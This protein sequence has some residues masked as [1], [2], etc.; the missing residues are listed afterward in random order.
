MANASDGIIKATGASRRSRL[1]FQ[2]MLGNVIS[3]QARHAL[4]GPGGPFELA[5]EPV[6]GCPHTVF[7]R[8]PKTLRETLNTRSADYLDLV[9]LCSPDRTWTF[10][11]ALSHIDALAVLLAERYQ[12]K[13]GDRVAIVAANSAEYALLMWAT[14]TL[15]AIVT[16]LNGWWTEPELLAGVALTR[17]VLIAGDERR[18]AR[19]DRGSVPARVP[20]RLIDGLLAEAEAYRGQAPDAPVITEDSPAVI[21]FT[22]GTTG[23]PKGATLSHRNLINFGMVQMLSG[24]LSAAAVPGAGDAAPAAPPPQTTTIVTSPMF[25]I[26]GL[27]GVF[28]TG[29]FAHAKLV[30]A[31][32]G[33]WDP[34][35]YLALTTEHAVTAWSGVPTH[36]WR[37]L[38]HPEL[39]CY[40]VS[41]VVSVG[42]GGATFPPQLVR[43]LH[44]RF[45]NIRLGSGYGMSESTGLGTFT[46]GDLFLRVPDSAGP[47]QPTV[48]VQIRDE[49]GT[50]LGAGEIGQ[51][52][53]RTPSIF[54]GYWDDPSATAAVLDRERWYATGDYGCISSGML[55]LQSRR[56]DLILRGGENIY[57]VE[58]ENR[59]LE[60][61]QIDDAA[62]IGV[63]HPELGQQPK[64]FIVGAPGSQLCPAEVRDWC[65]LALARYKVPADV[66]FVAALPYNAAGKLLKQELERQDR[67]RRLN[68]AAPPPAEG[69]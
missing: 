53:L 26:S 29:G 24:A 8:R 56:R 58:I 21:L 32:P 54:L 60:H 40:D 18:L 61:P 64:A 52:H 46:G 28:I 11:D 6:L 57:P 63:D 35:V 27:V 47:A 20:V 36:F 43:D 62:V 34:A 7:A 14:V 39:G 59:L 23:R 5:T 48:E 1:R 22:S 10:R 33:A 12:V 13:A 69:R 15:G 30:F 55:Y 49:C 45:P 65:A 38:R 42:A 66:E 16:S 31:R 17:P 9:F 67:E 3:A 51:I 25:H 44:G 37:I 2:F 50:V 4:L 68:P 41:S 19:F